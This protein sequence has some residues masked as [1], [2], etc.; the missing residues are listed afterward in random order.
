MALGPPPI[1]SLKPLNAG[2]GGA[3]AVGGAAAAI[4]AGDKG[5]GM[6]FTLGTMGFFRVYFRLVVVGSFKGFFLGRPL[7]RLGGSESPSRKKFWAPAY[8]KGLCMRSGDP[9]TGPPGP[10]IAW[11]LAPMGYWGTRPAHCCWYICCWAAAAAAA[12]C[13][14]MA[15]T[16]G[17]V[18]GS[19]EDP[20]PE[21]VLPVRGKD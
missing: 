18:K 2:P 3:C 7:F 8:E 15:S 19:W 1:T 10:P 9:G 6:T 11:G 17:L 20:V 16:D 5:P 14:C 4:A 12:C 13:I 21:V